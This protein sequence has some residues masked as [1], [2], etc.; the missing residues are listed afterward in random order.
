MKGEIEFKINNSGIT[1]YIKGVVPGAKRRWLHGE[2]AD[3]LHCIA[4]KRF[5]LV[6]DGLYPGVGRIEIYE[7]DRQLLAE[8]LRRLEGDP[9]DAQNTYCMQ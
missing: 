4:L 8:V 6:G 5:K 7:A 2:E 9:Q 1:A 3:I